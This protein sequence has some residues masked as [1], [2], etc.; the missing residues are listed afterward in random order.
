MS[1]IGDFATTSV[2]SSTAYGSLRRH[3]ALR[4][5]DPIRTSTTTSSIRANS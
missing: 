5:P 2:R 4:S 3:I 1:E